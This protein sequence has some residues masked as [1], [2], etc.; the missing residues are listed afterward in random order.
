MSRVFSI[1]TVLRMVPH[2]LLRRFFERLGHTDLP[3]PWAQLKKRDPRPVLAAV[4]GLEAAQVDAIE[5]AL[6]TVFDLACDTGLAAIRESAEFDD[7]PAPLADVPDDATLYHHAMAAWVANP[8]V[9]GRAMRIHQVERLTW[10]RKR[11]DL[12]PGAL[13][14]SRGALD[15]FARELSALLLLS[16]GRGRNCTVEHMTRKGTEYVFAHPDDFAQNVT[17]HTRD[18]ELVPRTFRH[19][20][21]I[22]FAFHPGEGTLETFAKLPSKTKP[23]VEALFAQQFLGVEHLPRWPRRPTY[24]LDQLKPRA[25]DLDTDPADRVRAEVRHMRLRYP[26]SQRQLS[27]TGDPGFPRDTHSLLDDALNQDRVPLTDLEL[28][29]VTLEFVFL[30]GSDPPAVSLDVACPS[31]CSLR[32]LPPNRAELVQ[33]YLRRWGIDADGDVAAAG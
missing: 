29:M 30:D 26:N 28:T 3:I 6:H 13:D 2:D 31:S 21:P 23:K 1:P 17:A 15:R 4:Q 5:A 33:K 8:D 32:N 18:G 10:W 24:H 16:E 12:P 27:F 14:G 25:F 11:R 20:F 9:I 19:T 22:I 7:G